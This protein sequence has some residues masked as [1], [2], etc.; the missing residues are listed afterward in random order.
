MQ[1]RS[2]FM[3]VR[4]LE[5]Y[6]HFGNSP[7][8]LRTIHIPEDGPMRIPAMILAFVIG[9]LYLAWA[10]IGIWRAISRFLG[11]NEQP[12]A[13]TSGPR[14]IATK[15]RI[16]RHPG[17]HESSTDPSGTRDRREEGLYDREPI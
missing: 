2:E 8:P 15:A 6:P 5:A 13:P 11:L 3:M 10:A 4:V 17:T 14:R 9:V 16:R 1:H 12:D 7:W